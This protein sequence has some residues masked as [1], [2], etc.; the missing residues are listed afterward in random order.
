MLR[1]LWKALRA[2]IRRK[3]EETDLSEELRGYV[4]A[5]AE[6]KIAAGMSREDALRAAKAE[7]GSA[8]AVKDEVR[9][10]GWEAR[11]YSIAQD[12]RYGWR[13]LRTNPGFSATAIISLAV[14]IG[15]NT[16]LFSLVD[17]VYL[18]SLPVENPERLIAFDWSAGEKR[19]WAGIDGV[20]RHPHGGT[21][22]SSFSVRA[23][24]RIR[25]NNSTMESVFAFAPMEQLNV[26]I[27]GEAEVANGQLVSG[28]YFRGLGARARLGRTIDES[29]DRLGASGTAV[30]SFRYWISRFAGSSSA[31][32]KQIKINNVP[33]TVV[34]VAPK[35]FEG[36][37]DYWENNAF[38]IPLHME[39]PVRGPVQTVYGSPLLQWL[40]LMGR[41]KPG[42]TREQVIANVEPVYRQGAVDD[43]NAYAP[44][45]VK[46]TRTVADA[47]HL[48]P[49][50]GAQGVTDMRNGYDKPVMVLSLVV[51]LVLM[52]ACV[53]VANMLLARGT[54]RQRE[55]GVRLAL[56]AARWRV[57]RQLMTESLLLG[58]ASGFLGIAV[59]YFIKDMMLHVIPFTISTISPDLNWRVLGFTLVVSVLTSLVFGTAP[60]FRAMRVQITP[61]LKDT[62]KSSQGR[63]GATVGKILVAAQVAL[64]VVLLVGAGLYVRTLVNLYRVDV[65]FNTKNLLL[66]RVNPTMSGYKRDQLAGV[67]Q[68]LTERIQ[69]VPGVKSVT[70]SRHPLLSLGARTS[71]T[72]VPNH[73]PRDSKVLLIAPNFLQTMEIPLLAGRQLN[74]GDNEK[75]PKVAIVNESFMRAYFDGRNPV[76]SSFWFGSAQDGPGVEI[77]GV[78]GDAHYTDLRTANPPTIYIPYFQEVPVQVNFEVRSATEPQALISA[79][80]A[81]ARDVDANLPLFDIKT[82][83]EQAEESITQEKMFAMLTSCF[84]FSAVLLSAIGL[85]GL[86]SYAVARRT[87]EIAIRMALG[88]RRGRVLASIVRETLVMVIA[89]IAAGIPLTLAIGQIA[90][91]VVADMLFGLK[92]NDPATV[93]LAIAGL[94]VVGAVAAYIPARRAASVDPMV[95]LRYE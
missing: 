1:K 76:G 11:F 86:M 29:D 51:A 50:P 28:T 72:F 34:G 45:S 17:A 81:A 89:G 22:S 87:N 52:I 60:A 46:V 12:L 18:K 71:T 57:M 30:I 61:A 54:S 6:Q 10:V 15:A 16:A 47:P 82:Q 65:G 26:K 37:M 23:F 92:Q 55:I 74:E 48:R 2:V 69:A 49:H 27:D 62:A 56:G 91:S 19:T 95:A 88:A 8:E 40:R 85:Y 79:V 80:Q 90:R 83:T 41:M 66:F 14:A 4:E 39:P 78:A 31:I 58:I 70:L 5:A 42:V 13:M 35:N 43:W 68:R 77:V 59:A 93:A 25:D 21:E 44:P 53:N 64:S 94:L 7:L 3:Q 38:F 75:A 73:A 32:G 24:E 84:G 20:S 33:F 67:Y 9:D 36:A 63:A